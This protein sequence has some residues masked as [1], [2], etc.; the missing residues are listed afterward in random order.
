MSKNKNRKF[1][2]ETMKIIHRLTD[3][4]TALRCK[5]IRLE[6]EKISLCV[7]NGNLNNLLEQYRQ[8]IQS[9]AIKIE[10]IP[11]CFDAHYVQLSAI[12]D[13]PERQILNMRKE[14]CVDPNVPHIA[15]CIFEDVK[16]DFAHKLFEKITIK[17]I[18]NCLME[19]LNGQ[20]Y[21]N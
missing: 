15:S 2:R 5:N 14:I 21:N 7:Q 20:T 17:N 11:N 19:N 4:T 12:L 3:E 16:N 8:F 13:A 18:P 6:N 9:P 10:K 1:K